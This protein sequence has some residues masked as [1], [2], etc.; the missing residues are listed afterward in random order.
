MA[1]IAKPTI[2]L[3]NGRWHIPESYAKLAGGLRQAGFEVHVPRNPS[4]NQSR[5]PNAD[6]T[7]DSNLIRG[8]AT[9][10]IEAS[11][12]GGQVGTNGLYGLSRN[13]RA[14]KGLPGGISKLIY[15]TTFAL[16]KGKAM[17]DKVAGFGQLGLMP[18]SFDFDED[19]TC[20][21]NY[22][23]RGLIG[24]NFANELDPEELEAYLATI[25]RWNGKCMYLPVQNTP[26]WRDDVEVCYI[27][28]LSDL[29]VPIGYQR[30]MV[31]Y[32]EKEGKTVRTV[33]IDAGHCPNL[34]AA[35]E[36]AEAIIKFSSD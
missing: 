28:T 13:A 12:T 17:T 36:V 16:P 6:L 27:Y 21:P 2:L 1:S 31:E 20:V 26:A 11:R 8:Y 24:E 32:I 22:R 15:L 23:K 33:E 19:Q 34:T 5:P 14:A 10:L 9:S 29:A 7:T 25:L 4:M 3:V 35:K 18:I 30:S